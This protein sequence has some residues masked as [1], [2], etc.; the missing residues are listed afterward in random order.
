MF[1]GEGC[2]LTVRRGERAAEEGLR[3]FQKG[4]ECFV[5]GSAISLTGRRDN[6]VRIQGFLLRKL[7][8]RR[9]RR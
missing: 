2:G 9:G 4:L 6:H 7:G 5:P 8:Q 3:L 1:L